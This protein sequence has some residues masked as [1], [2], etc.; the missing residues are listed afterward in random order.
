MR[1]EGIEKEFPDDARVQY[2]GDGKAVRVTGSNG[3]VLWSMP[4]TVLKAAKAEQKTLATGGKDFPPAVVKAVSLMLD[5]AQLQTLRTNE[6]VMLDFFHGYLCG[7][8][9]ILGVIGGA[10][11][12]NLDWLME[13]ENDDKR[14]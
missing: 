13:D 6:K 11:G 3:K 9:A 10:L 12:Y 2:S 4:P 8:H 1:I 7:A 14:S 5:N